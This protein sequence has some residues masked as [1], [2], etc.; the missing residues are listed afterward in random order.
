MFFTFDGHAPHV[1]KD[2]FVSETAQIIGDVTIGDDCY[3]GHGA[4]LRGDYGRIVIGSG[5]AIEEAVVI[6]APPGETNE[7]GERV[8]V[9]HG[10]ILHGKRI[11]EGA[12][13][14]MGAILSLRSEIGDGAIVGE[15]TVVTMKRTIPPRVVAVGNPARVIREVND[16]DT[17]FWERAKQL[18]VDLAKK[19]RERGLV[20]ATEIHHNIRN[21]CKQPYSPWKLD[22]RNG[23]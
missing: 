15:G 2:S 21:T 8:T 10:A 9:G 19:Y 3:I 22:C 12:V 14:G 1:G 11:G 23:N 5:S 7:I 17:A 16:D 13:I 18:Y 6:H 4:I 20:P